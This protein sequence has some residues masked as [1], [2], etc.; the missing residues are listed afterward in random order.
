MPLLAIAALAA[1]TY[2]CRLAGPVFRRQGAPLH[3][4]IA[5][6]L[7]NPGQERFDPRPQV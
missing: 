2:A 1:G 3:A 7:C 5:S 6:G 4:D